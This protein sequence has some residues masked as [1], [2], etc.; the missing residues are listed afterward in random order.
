[1]SADEPRPSE[2]RY[3]ESYEIHAANLKSWHLTS[4]AQQ[5]AEERFFALLDVSPPGWFRKSATP[6]RGTLKMAE[7]WKIGQYDAM[8]YC[9]RDFQL[10]ER[11][12]AFQDVNRI[13]RIAAN[14]PIPKDFAIH[15]ARAVVREE[16]VL[17]V[18]EHFEQG[19]QLVHVVILFIYLFGK[20]I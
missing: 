18:T 10:P 4:E 9:L 7:K 2:V 6:W 16:D 17:P 1:L 14:G 12:R 8:S 5:Q 3:L 19:H 20:Q 13:F 15:A 11:V